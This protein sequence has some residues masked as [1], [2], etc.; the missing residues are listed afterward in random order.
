MDFAYR[1]KY[2]VDYQGHTFETLADVG[3]RLLGQDKLYLYTED[4]EIAENLGFE[5]YDNGSFDK[6][7]YLRD[8]ERVT[9]LK[10]PILRFKGMETTKTI[11]EKDQILDYIINLIE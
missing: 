1:V 8:I 6:G 9:E 11:I 4:R 10:I 3:K 7:I 2:L 5:T